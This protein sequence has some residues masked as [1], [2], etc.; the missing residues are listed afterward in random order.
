[1]VWEWIRNVKKERDEAEITNEYI[2][3]KDGCRMKAEK[4]DV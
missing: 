2:C 4:R 1:M 3:S